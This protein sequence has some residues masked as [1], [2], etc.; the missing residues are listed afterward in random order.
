M[1]RLLHFERKQQPLL[2][3]EEFRTRL[4]RNVLAG[5]L[6]LAFFLGIGIWGYHATCGFLWLDK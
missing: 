5:L 1:R 6:I 2:S 3:L 4:L